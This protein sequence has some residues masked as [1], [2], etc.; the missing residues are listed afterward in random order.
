MTGTR[1]AADRVGELRRLLEHHNR[2][3]YAED[4]P[5]VSDA[6]YDRLMDELRRLEAEHPDLLTPD[7]PSQRV[8]APPAERF[9]PVRHAKPM[10]SLANARNEEELRAWHI[11]L[12]G[13]I[14]KQEEDPDAVDFVI[15]PKVDGL[16][17]SLLYEGGRFVRGATRGDGEVGEDVTRNLRTVKA[18]PKRLED[19]PA[20]LEVRGEVYF[21]RSAFTRLNEERAEAGQPTFANPRNAAAGSLRQLDPAITASRPLSMWCYGVGVAEGV[22]LPTQADWLEWLGAHGFPVSPGVERHAELERV[23]EACRGWEERREGLDFE[24]DGAVVKLNQLDLSARLGVVGREPRGAI[25]WKFAPMTATTVLRSVEWNVGRTGHLVPFGQLDPVQISGVTVKVATLHNEEDLRRK[26][27][28]EGDEVIVTRAGDVIPQIVSPSPAAQARPDR[29]PVPEPPVRCPACQTATV[30][31]EGSAWTICPNRA[32]CPGQLHQ[33]VKHFVSRGA[34]DIEGLG[35]ER[36]LV[37]LREGLIHDVAEIYDLTAERLQDLEGFA[38]LSARGLV[39][40]VETSKARPFQRVLYALGIPGIGFVNARALVDRFRSMDRILAAPADEI[41][42]TP[43]IGPVLAETLADTLAEPRTRD[44]VE[45]LRA[46]GLRMEEEGPPLP[47]RGPLGG[48]ALV[49]TGTL[50]TLSREDATALIEG[51]GGRVTG[52]VSKKTAY[53]VAGEDPGS[54][55]AKAESLGTPVLDEAALLAL[56]DDGADAPPR[57]EDGAE[58]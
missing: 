41:E 5:E 36:A 29:G 49:L 30:K 28:R 26:D 52:S 43:G 13:L 57:V 48:K 27:V 40:A 54:K 3:Y 51:A 16:A 6:E 10:L 12:V 14:A 35:E 46:H 38:E 11:R 22:E 34:M 33:A 19:A 47:A 23:V 20:R 44:L 7:S 21:P 24:T 9:E 17:I 25:A 50:P 18:I 53:L 39:E 58:G 2:L 56:L 8:G 15:E 32:S 55:I 1:T 31:P 42:E 4:A 37:L 45:R